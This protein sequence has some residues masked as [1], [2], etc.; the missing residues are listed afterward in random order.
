MAFRGGGVDGLGDVHGAT[1]GYCLNIGKSLYLP[2]YK[3]DVRGVLRSLYSSISGNN[4]YI[5]Y[6]KAGSNS[7]MD[8]MMGLSRKRFLSLFVGLCGIAALSW[9]VLYRYYQSSMERM[10]QQRLQSLQAE[11]HQAAQELDQ[12]LY[13]YETLAEDLSEKLSKGELD[14]AQLMHY[15]E[16]QVRKDPNIYGFGVAMEPY[17]MS[18]HRKLFAPYYVNQPDGVELRFIDTSYD[19]RKE[20]WYQ[21]P[22]T[23]G[24][25][26]YESAFWG[27]VAQSLLAEYSLPFTETKQSKTDTVGVVYID[28]SLESVQNI[29]QEI[30]VG[31]S[32]Y[33]FLLGATGH[34]MAH[35]IS[36]WPKNGAHIK[37]KAQALEAPELVRLYQSTKQ[38]NKKPHPSVLPRYVDYVNPLSGQESRVLMERLPKTEWT[39]GITA[40]AQGFQPSFEK[41]KEWRMML[42]AALISMVTL[43]MVFFVYMWHFDYW[44][45]W[46][47]ALSL[48]LFYMGNIT[49]I[50]SLILQQPAETKQENR[51]VVTDKAVLEGFQNRYDSLLTRMHEQ[52]PLKVPTGV[53]IE[54]VEFTDANTI[55]LSGYIWQHYDSS[56]MHKAYEYGVSFPETAPTAGS[57]TLTPS[58]T[59]K[60]EGGIVRGWYFRTSVRNR[61][62]YQLYPFDRQEIRLKILPENAME[63]VILVP[64]LSAYSVNNPSMLPGLSEDISIPGWSFLGSFFNYG[65]ELY[66]TNFGVRG[67]LGHHK[68]PELSFNI[69]VRRDFLGPFISNIVPLLV[70]SLLLFTVVTTATSDRMRIEK[71]GFTGF[72]VLELTA[73][74]L[75]VAILAQ[76][77]L[78][79]KLA[80]DHILYMDY[81]YFMIYFVI[82]AY[83]I[84]S[85]LFTREKTLPFI[86]YKNNFYPRL[87]Y[88]PLFTGGL[89][90]VTFVLF[91]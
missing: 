41:S 30:E 68:F 88:W 79:N 3:K 73:A 52:K 26:W 13:T 45:Y 16:Q 1:N 24:K 80:V 39:L 53:F 31:K 74:F 5:A 65:F 12:I 42:Q 58:Y 4:N 81:F 67:N 85:V 6:F 64:E 72:G 7:F 8:N 19:Y 44:L 82:L 18:S 87:L 10:E 28:L 15:L 90:L 61:L 25:G 40:L 2:T 83:S 66:N 49:Y 77:D 55:S 63:H 35:P 17:Q 70:I 36:S 69:I 78:R 57:T 89:L 34:Y 54:H 47:L 21:E 60:K 33:P 71:V 38:G 84:N 91:F 51:L 9:Y 11:A 20:Q 56:F 59:L 43:L 76:I 46:I 62:R 22:F 27:V 86:H 29:L 75:F 14:S 48:G 50:W 32:G 23:E 37:K